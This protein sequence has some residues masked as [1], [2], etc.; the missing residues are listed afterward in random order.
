MALHIQS[1]RAQLSWTTQDAYLTQSGNGGQTLQLSSTKP[2]LEIQTKLPKVHIDQTQPFAE[3]GRKNIRAFMEDSVAYGR[4][5]LSRGI[6]RIVSDGN[7]WI[8]IHT[9][10]DPIPDQA[11]YNAYGQFEKDF[12]YGPM[13]SSR[14]QIT[15]DEGRVTY[16]FQ[17]GRVD[18]ASQARRVAFEYHPWRVDY[19][20][21]QYARLDIRAE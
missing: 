2:Q 1:Q 13:P 18:N 9:G 3:A 19:A 15:L 4:T 11:E 21:K 5:V 20:M 10:V 7:A 8:D 14:P 16:H 12:T 17:K 6:D